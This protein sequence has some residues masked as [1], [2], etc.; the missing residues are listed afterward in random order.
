LEIYFLCQIVRFSVSSGNPNLCGHVEAV[1]RAMRRP[2]RPLQL[3][4]LLQ[5]PR[6]ADRDGTVE[7]TDAHALLRALGTEIPPD[8][9][10]M[11]GITEGSPTALEFRANVPPDQ[12]RD[13]MNR[14]HYLRSPRTDACVYGLFTPA[15][16]LAVV[17]TVSSLDV[18]RLAELVCADGASPASAR[19][20]SRV[21]AF[22]DAPKNSISY[23]LARVSRAE[24]LA[25]VI[26][27]VTYV[28]PN[29]GFTGASYRASGWRL[30][31]EERG[32]AYR[33]LDGRYITDRELAR[34][35][36]PHDDGA[37]RSLLGPR[38]SVTAMPLL[39]LLIFGCGTRGRMP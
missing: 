13:V 35:F 33:Y 17:C 11:A 7:A 28:N 6:L 26:E 8:L 15:G 9:E 31:G 4:A 1:A 27:L 34:R 14:F 25:G 12:A 24:H 10:W 38:F 39:P 5:L 2:S 3:Q 18:P 29:L 37:Y 23:L 16:R 36:G 22:E 21:F 32:T 30:L 20:V 19:V